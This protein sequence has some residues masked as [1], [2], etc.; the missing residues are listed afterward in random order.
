MKY[1]HAVETV[2]SADPLMIRTIS[3]LDNISIIS[4]SDR[5]S[6]NFHR[7]GRETTIFKLNN[8]NYRNL[9]D[10]IRDNKIIKTYEFKPS[11]GKYYY[12]SLAN[13]SIITRIKLRF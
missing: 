11:A 8:L 13:N 5:H 1:I 2:L 10:S 3:D 7:L 9:I 6:T 12:D 4:S